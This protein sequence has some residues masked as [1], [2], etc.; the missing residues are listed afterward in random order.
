MEHTPILKATQSGERHHQAMSARH[1]VI[2]GR[3]NPS[4][5]VA[6]MNKLEKS[7]FIKIKISV[8]R[9]DSNAIISAMEARAR[10]RRVKFQIEKLE[11]E[12]LENLQRKRETLWV[13]FLQCCPSKRARKHKNTSFCSKGK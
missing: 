5:D 6:N 2:P 9:V 13:L 7:Y 3:Y 11:Q 1:R 12:T 10:Q 8:N 4:E